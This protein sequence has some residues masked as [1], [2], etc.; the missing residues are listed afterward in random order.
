MLR[1]YGFGNE[2]EAPEPDQDFY[3]VNARQYL[4]YPTFAVPFGKR[5]VFTI[6]PAIKYTQGDTDEDQLINEAKPYGSGNFGEAAVHGVL[7]WEGR[8]NLVFPRRGFFAAVRGTYFPEVW[9]VESDFGEV[10]GNANLY[11]S[12]GRVATLAL[13]VGGKKVFGTYPY[14][15][16][17]PIGEGGL[18]VGALAEPEDTLRGYR[19]RRYIGDSSAWGNAGLRL[20]VSHL[21]LILPGAWG[22][23]RVRRR[24]ARLARGRVERHVAHR[25]GRRPVGI[26]PERPHGLLGRARP[27]HGGRHRLRQRR[28]Q[29]L[30]L[31]SFD[32]GTNVWPCCG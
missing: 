19:A 23:P 27:Q 2:T 5:G 12:A 17:A 26:V 9:D 32:H 6:G 14:M 10:N 18:G 20:R 8:D 16:A 7:S 13:R 11:L 21:N 1:F 28:L 15:E 25:R 29:L 22:A 24:R 3:K 4:L 31:R 30:S